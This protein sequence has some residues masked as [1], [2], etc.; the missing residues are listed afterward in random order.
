MKILLAED[1]ND[2]RE[3]VTD[4]LEYQGH[5]VRAV[6]DGQKALEAAQT[7]AF[8][9]ILMDIMMPV[10]DGLTAMRKLRERG[11]MTPAIFLT[12]KGEVAD[13]VEGLDAGADDYLTKPFALEELGARLRAMLRRKRDYQVR[14]YSCGN[15]ELDTETSEL[16][17]HNSIGLSQREVKLM[18]LLLSSRDRSFTTAELLSEVWREEDAKEDSVWMYITFLRAKLQSI[19]ADCVIEGERG[20]SFRLKE[21]EG[22]GEAHV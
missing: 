13:R 8:D 15:T 1:E 18:S 9:V 2:L 19:R 10:M 12:A 6:P 22:A 16:R 20:G 4:Y 5:A 11:D 21:L 17:A 14:V 3:V 7:D